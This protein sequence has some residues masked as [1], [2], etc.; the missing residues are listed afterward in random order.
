MMLSLVDFRPCRPQQQ[1]NS[2]SNHATNYRAQVQNREPYK[3]GI[4]TWPYYQISDRHWVS[5]LT[6]S[7][8]SRLLQQRK[9]SVHIIVPHRTSSRPIDT[10]HSNFQ[11]SKTFAH[12]A[13]P[14]TR[15]HNRTCRQHSRRSHSNQVSLPW[16]FLQHT[17]NSSFLCKRSCLARAC[18]RRLVLQASNVLPRLFECGGED[19]E[20]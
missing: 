17:M 7:I 1:S 6:S 14:H 5:Y 4:V 16:M 13:T 20:G 12:T 15:R 10:S 18:Q 11:S 19:L 3:L 9:S 2:F 8:F